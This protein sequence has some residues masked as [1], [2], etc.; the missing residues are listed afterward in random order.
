VQVS[1]ERD[2]EDMGR[3]TEI[4]YKAESLGKSAQHDYARGIGDTVND[5]FAYQKFTSLFGE[6]CIPCSIKSVSSEN[7][8]WG[9]DI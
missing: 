8:R 9:S 3:R 2:S 4:S 5:A 6:I 1:E 7:H